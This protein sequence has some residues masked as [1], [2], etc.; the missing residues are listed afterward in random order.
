MSWSIGF[1]R[2]LVLN[3]S[4]NFYPNNILSSPTNFLPKQI[5]LKREWEVAISEI[6][7]PSLY[8]SFTFL[9]VLRRKE[10][11]YPCILNQDCI[12]VLLI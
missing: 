10:K 3:A 6:P 4:F 2:N 8:Q 1:S 5:H 9:Q 7:Y 11:S 12:Q